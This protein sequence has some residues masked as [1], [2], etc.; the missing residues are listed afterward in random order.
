MIN[1]ANLVFTAARSPEAYEGARKSLIDAGVNSVLLDC[2]DSHQL[3]N[4]DQKDRIGNC[5]TWIK[6]DS[7]FQGLLQALQEFDERVYIGDMPPKRRKAEQSKT[8]FIGSVKV[9]KK[10]DSELTQEWFNL[11]IPLNPDLVAIIGNKGSGKSA[12]SDIIALAGNTRHHDK[13]SFLKINRF[14]DRKTK[15][16]SHFEASLLWLDNVASECELDKDPDPTAVERVKHLPQSYLEELCNELGTGESSTFDSELRK[17]IYS[18]VPEADRLGKASMNDLLVFK[19]AEIETA[20]E[21][22]RKEL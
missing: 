18:H 10:Q 20:L 15:F 12:L 13:F 7:T 22:I 8:K 2:S 4:S 21:A 19:V 14:R 11:E 1:E 3:S 9:S 5:F 16:A 6:A 17:I